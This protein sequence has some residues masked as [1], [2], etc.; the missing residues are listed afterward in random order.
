MTE[1]I[2]DI[3][4]TQIK[5]NPH[6]P[7]QEFDPGKLQELADS[8]KEH[9]I[10]QPLIVEPSANG[11]THILTAGER[12]WRAAQL[13]GLTH[14]PC[15]V[16]A[17]ADDRQRLELAL[18]ENVQREDLS[19]AEEAR[20]YQQL[21][22][23]FGL[24]DEQIGQRVGKAR[25]T[26]ANLRR[27]A[28]LPADVL[29]LIGE[30]RGQLKIR[31]ARQLIAVSRLVKPDALTRTA[32]A[33]AKLD[34][35]ERRDIDQHLASLIEKS[36]QLM[37]ASWDRAWPKTPIPLPLGD[38]GTERSERGGKDE[39]DGGVRSIPACTGCESYLVLHGRWNGTT[40]YCLNPQCYAAKDK[41]FSAHELKRVSDKTGI[42][43]AADGDA[44]R[45]APLTLNHSVIDKVRRWIA[46]AEAGHPP[47][48]LR[49]TL[50][51]NPQR[52]DGHYHRSITESARVFLASVDPDA[53]KDKPTPSTSSRA[54]SA[55]TSARPAPKETPE[56]KAARLK[57]EEETRR[58]LEAEAQKERLA[59]RKVQGQAR[60]AH[61]DSTW[62]LT[63]AAHFVATKL[64]LSGLY[65][66]VLAAFLFEEI[67]YL[68]TETASERLDAIDKAMK[69]AKGQAR[70]GLLREQ[71][72]WFLIDS[73]SPREE[74]WPA[75][76]K[77]VTELLT[78]AGKGR[79]FGLKLPKDLAA[80]PIYHTA[81]N[82][83]TCGAFA[84]EETITAD[85]LS[86]GWTIQRASQQP[87]DVR[88]P[89]CSKK[90]KPPAAK[91][92]AK[93]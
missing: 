24:T 85:D 47:E 33:I 28:E 50:N 63:A 22:A 64:P 12:R 80:P 29:N 40:E 53:L 57:A 23:E 19:A 45:A 48:H 93:K 20:A 18:I 72:T 39:G 25:S 3:A 76:K 82:C 10:Q 32:A 49:L 56:A 43:S 54:A 86:D 65:L 83:W 62:L 27:L 14:V 55:S 7:R 11:G 31:D 59:R 51:G 34:P 36:A 89:A 77:H 88:C 17:V 75:V 92:K 79:G 90:A 81:A 26:I 6:Q 73:G 38:H 37:V 2:I 66:D 74:D 70:E 8:I 84:P 58:Q 78:G 4:V 61:A 44:Q 15:I 46:A 16:R 52:A 41:L 67:S 30:G 91:A 1:Q 9:G 21:H 87:S 35:D 71:I 5:P 42:P 60:K 13:A 68:N 69:S